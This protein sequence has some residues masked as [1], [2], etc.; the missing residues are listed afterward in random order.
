MPSAPP[1]F[2]GG[3]P[4]DAEQV[5]RDRRPIPGIVPSSTRSLRARRTEGACSGA[6]RCASSK[7][8]SHLYLREA[9]ATVYE[10]AA[11]LL[12]SLARNHPLAGGNTRLGLA[13]LI[14]FYGMNGLRL[15]FTDDEAYKLVAAVAGWGARGRERQ[16]GTSRVGDRDER[17]PDGSRPLPQTQGVQR[18]LPGLI[19]AGLAAGRPTGRPATERQRT[20]RPGGGTAVARQASVRDACGGPARSRPGSRGP[21]ARTAVAESDRRATSVAPS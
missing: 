1:Q 21:G 11:A 16:R 4:L 9:Y 17:L 7:P 14:A 2:G 3:V 18:T 20:R 12:H 15:T 5:R 10:K 19:T 13:S 6:R 8:A